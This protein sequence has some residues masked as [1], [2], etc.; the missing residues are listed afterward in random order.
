MTIGDKC[1]TAAVG[2]TMGSH[3]KKANPSEQTKGSNES[4]QMS[5]SECDN[6]KR[7]HENHLLVVRAVRCRWRDFP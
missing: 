5:H 6:Q 4:E 1:G 3:W 2:Q 7:A